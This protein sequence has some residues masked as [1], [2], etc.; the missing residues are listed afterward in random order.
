[1]SETGRKAGS[2]AAGLRRVR[3]AMA[4]PARTRTAAAARPVE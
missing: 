2:V 3:R 4:V 1:M